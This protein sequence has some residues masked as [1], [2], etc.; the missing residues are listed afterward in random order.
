[1]KQAVK[2]GKRAALVCRQVGVRHGGTRMG[3]DGSR[4][5]QTD[6]NQSNHTRVAANY[7][8]TTLDGLHLEARWTQTCVV[9]KMW[10]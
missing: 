1:M 9:S 8:P 4:P 5:G 6:K 7:L 2:R 10:G 3:S